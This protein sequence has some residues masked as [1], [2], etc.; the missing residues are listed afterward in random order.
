M[1]LAYNNELSFLKFHAV[2]DFIR[3]PGKVIFDIS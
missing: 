1:S 3:L 2:K